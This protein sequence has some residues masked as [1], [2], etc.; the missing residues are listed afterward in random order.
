MKRSILKVIALALCLTLLA[1]VLP[2]EAVGAGFLQVR[3][4]ASSLFPSASQQSADL[5]SRADAL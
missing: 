3:A 5:L 1:P 2:L 4:L